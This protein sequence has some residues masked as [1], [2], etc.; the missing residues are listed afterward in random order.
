M[1]SDLETLMTQDYNYHQDDGH[2]IANL[3]NDDQLKFTKGTPVMSGDPT[4]EEMLAAMDDKMDGYRETDRYI[5]RTSK[6][7]IAS[8]DVARLRELEQYRP[9]KLGVDLI[10][11]YVYDKIDKKVIKYW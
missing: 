1:K 4:Y 2:D 7:P 5:V 11:N 10:S 9:L 8:N 3:V 6:D